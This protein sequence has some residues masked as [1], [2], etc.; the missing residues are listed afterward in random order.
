MACLLP[1]RWAHAPFGQGGP[2]RD[3]EMP[4]EKV[5]RVQWIYCAAAASPF[6][7]PGERAAA[8]GTD[9]PMVLTVLL[10]AVELAYYAAAGALG[11]NQD[12]W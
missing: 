6:C 1:G 3:D 10:A 7:A 9:G 2:V 4:A 11:W 8:S 12:T 5:A